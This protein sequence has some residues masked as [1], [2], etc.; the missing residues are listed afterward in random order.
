MVT[1][2]VPYMN[3]SRLWGENAWGKKKK[4]KGGRSKTQTPIQ[5]LPKVVWDML[6]TKEKKQAKAIRPM[7]AE[8]RDFGGSKVELSGLYLL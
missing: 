3:S 7:R 4:R 1:I 6:K 5:T 2:H 8:E